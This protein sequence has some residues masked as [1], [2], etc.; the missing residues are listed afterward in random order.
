MGIH[1][2][3]MSVVPITTATIYTL[4][5]SISIGGVGCGVGCGKKAL[6]V[7]KQP[8]ALSHTPNK[9]LKS[10]IILCIQLS[11]NH[12]IPELC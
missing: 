1:T 10:H 9:K 5:H 12:Y 2:V 11:P 3:L 8:S 4:V 7:A 6:L